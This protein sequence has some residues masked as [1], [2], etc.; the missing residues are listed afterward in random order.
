MGIKYEKEGVT[1]V[2]QLKQDVI[3]TRALISVD[4]ACVSKQVFVCLKVQR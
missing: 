2:L 3:Y 4:A 1:P